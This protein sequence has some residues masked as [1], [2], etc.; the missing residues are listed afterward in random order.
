M[1]LEIRFVDEWVL[2]VRNI[3]YVIRIIRIESESNCNCYV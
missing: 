1:V 2:P 3:P